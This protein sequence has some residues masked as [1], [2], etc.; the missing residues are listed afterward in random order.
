MGRKKIQIVYGRDKENPNRVFNIWR[1]EAIALANAGFVVDKEPL[2]ESEVLLYRGP[3]MPVSIDYPKDS[4]YIHNFEINSN[5]LFM[6]KYYP[7]ISDLSIETYI[8][9]DLDERVDQKMEELGWD[10]VFIKKD[11]KALEYSDDGNKC[12]YPET[13]LEEM[14][15]YYEEYQTV[16]KYCV[17]K[18]IESERLEA[19]RRY[20]VLNGN[21]YVHDNIVPDIVREAAKRLD[22]FGGKYYTIDA[23]PEFI[24]EVNPGESSDRHAVNSAELFASWFW[25]E[26]GH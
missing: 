26:F 23:T 17:R 22:K 9:D 14:K 18:F 4:R 11:Q 13:S 6:S 24:I 12:F 3:S 21:I 16:G 19:D 7:L 10:K 15:K 25:K 5:Y 20:W 8:F 2:P 1:S